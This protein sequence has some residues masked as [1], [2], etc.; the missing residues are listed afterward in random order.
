ML[1]FEKPVTELEGKLKELRHIDLADGLDLADEISRLEVQA[2]K[3]LTQIYAKLTPWQKTQVAR[4]VDRPHATDY[5]SSIVS[6]FT[7]LAGDRLFAEDHAIIG[8]PGWFGDQAI[9]IIGQQKGRDTEDRVKHNFGMAQPE[10]YRKAIR[11]MKMADRFGLPVLNL[12]DTPGAYPGIG[13][14]ERGQAEAIAQSI[15]TMTAL[16]VPTLSIVIGEGGSG[17]AI[18]LATSDRVLMLE[19]AV[20]SVIS[21]EGCAAILWRDAGQ[22]ELAAESM[23]LTS[24]DLLSLRIIDRIIEEPLGGA[25]RAPEDMT[26]RVRDEISI[27]LDSLM[28]L[29]KDERVSKRDERFLAMTRLSS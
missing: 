14:E 21:P 9:M 29:S 11:L 19:H 10:G 13:A 4:H 18:A 16:N 7:P 5:I 26:D 20:Y 25:H 3:L 24:H 27:E 22:A 23:K 17:G 15:E 1:D 8:G 6:D 2:N 28:R 12:I